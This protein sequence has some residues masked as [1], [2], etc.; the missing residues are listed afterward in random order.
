MAD[1]AEVRR[2]A[3]SLPQAAKFFTE[4]HYHGFPAILIRLP[5]IETDELRELLTDP[6]RC[7]A[8]RTL[9]KESGL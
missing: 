8:P 1:Q 6:W 3:L 4:P 2:I 7:Q 5:A 9:A